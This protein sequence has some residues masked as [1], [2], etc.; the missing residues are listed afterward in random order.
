MYLATEFDPVYWNTA[1]LIV[2]SGGADETSE[3]SAD[4]AKIAAAIGDIKANG[5]K[6]SLIDINKSGFNFAPDRETNSILY[7][8]RG[9]AGVGAAIIN[10]IIAN[11]PYSSIE[12]FFDRTKV[13]KAVGIALIKSGAFDSMIDRKRA[14]VWYVLRNTPTKSKLTLANVREMITKNLIP[15]DYAFE[16]SVFEFN[17]YLKAKC[18]A[19]SEEYLVDDR[20]MKF[21]ETNF[22]DLYSEIL[23]NNILDAAIWDKYFYKPTMER[24]KEWLKEFEPELLRQINDGNF[25]EQWAKY[26]GTANNLLSSWEMESACFYFHEHELADINFGKYNIVQFE[27][28][29]KEP[30]VDRSFFKNEKTI[31]LYKIKTICGTVLAKNPTKS[32]ISLLTPLGTVVNVKFS[33]EYYAMFDKQISVVAADGKK[34]VME[35]S[36]FKRGNMLVINGYREG[37]MFRAKKYATTKGHTLCKITK[38][39]DGNIELQS[40]RYKGGIL[41]QDEESYQF[42]KNNNYIEQEED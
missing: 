5:V 37:E 16:R 2:N 32:S 25:K 29:P 20:G 17:R 31:N 15:D 18:K 30:L 3:S 27:N 24:L 26:G 33:K 22:V 23:G 21:L 4:Y 41:E 8:F 11:R 1:C 28:L 7:G 35:R 40:E 12:D 9:L 19:N 42:F 39:Q 10:D 13:N 34:K 6:V 36:W 38:I 14:M